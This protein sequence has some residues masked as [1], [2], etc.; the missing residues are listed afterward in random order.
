MA[1]NATASAE[2]TMP[3]FVRAGMDFFSGK[4]VLKTTLDEA[5]RLREVAEGRVKELEAA[6]I[7]PAKLST[8]EEAVKAKDAEIASLKGKLST[9]EAS[10]QTAAQ[11]AREQINKAG[12]EKPVVTDQTKPNDGKV[13]FSDRVAAKVAAGKGK[14]SAIAECIK[15]FPTEYSEWL[16]GDTSKL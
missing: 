5:N 10:Y 11:Q 6:A 16:K 9:L 14:A 2:P 3:A 12:A 7:D 4:T 1:E 13:T 15:E 8:L